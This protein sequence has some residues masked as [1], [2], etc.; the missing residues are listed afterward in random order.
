MV[1]F[2]FPK[3]LRLLAPRYFDYVFQQAKR[4]SSSEIIILGRFNELDY[5]RIGFTIA[6]KIIKQAYQRNRIKRLMREYFRLHQNEFPSMDFV[7]LV[8]K[9]ITH[10]NNKEI[11][12]ILGKLWHRYC[13]LAHGY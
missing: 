6:K 2:S 9:E 10:L 5:P 7:V 13:H 12:E 4:V 3:E 11:I 1:M 8:R